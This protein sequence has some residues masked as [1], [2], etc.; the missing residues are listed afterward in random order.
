MDSVDKVLEYMDTWAKDSRLKLKNGDIKKGGH[1]QDTAK[2]Y[3]QFMV[4]LGTRF[5]EAEPLTITE[6]TECLSVSLQADEPQYTEHTFSMDTVHTVSDFVPA[7]VLAKG[8]TISPLGDEI[9]DKWGK[10]MN[11]EGLETEIV[12]QM[13]IYNEESFVEGK[14]VRRPMLIGAVKEFIKMEIRERAG[15]HWRTR[16]DDLV[17]NPQYAEYS[18]VY[19][20]GIIRAFSFQGDEGLNLAVLKQWIWQTKRFFCGLPVPDPLMVNLYAYKGGGG[21]TQIVRKLS[22]PLEE[23]TANST[24]E[25]ILDSRE[26]GLF[27]DRNIVFFDEMSLGKVEFGQIG[28]LM[29]GLKKLI[30]ED[31]IT[32]RNMRETTHSKKRRTFSP[33][34]TSNQPLAQL[35]PDDSGMR[36]FFEI[37][38]LATP[39]TTRV[40]R[41]RSLDSFCIW[42]GID[43]SLERGYI[44]EGSAIHKKLIIQQAGLKHRSILDDCL[45]AMEDLPVLENSIEGKAIL[46]LEQT[47]AKYS[48]LEQLAEGKGLTPY[49][50]YE[51]RKLVRD[52]CEDNMDK[53]LAKYLP[54]NARLP[55]DLI[56]RGFVVLQR[57][58]KNIR[59]LV[60]GED[61]GGA[62]I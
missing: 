24:L 32:Q 48:E 15:Q 53:F 61:L 41:L 56:A 8:I 59:I 31:K 50:V 1:I 11:F 7:A 27:T 58:K 52:W 45:D 5:P 47:G 23:Y 39:D 36:R 9:T 2:L 44:V 62:H 35:L 42:R 46:E 3:G 43:E 38:M 13:H 6:F 19:L 16:K 40:Q 10:S 17:F 30:T 4:E 21:K 18:D 26:H 34:A 51:Y 55:Q 14:A 37:E 33:I 28:P 25:T 57:D 29:A 49:K 20:L 22:Q 12:C 60:K 54:G